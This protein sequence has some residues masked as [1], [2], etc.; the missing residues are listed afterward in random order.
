MFCGQCGKNLPDDVRFCQSCGRPTA[1]APIPTSFANATAAAAAPAPALSS[2]PAPGTTSDQQLVKHYAEMSDQELMNVA[3]DVASLEDDARMVIASELSRRKLSE[4]DI[5][6]YQQD[7]AAFKP[8]DFWRELRGVRGWLFLFCASTTIV[9]PIFFLRDALSSSGQPITFCVNLPMAVFAFYT[10][11]SLWR[12]R[13]NALKLV[14]VY[15]LVQL[16]LAA[17]SFLAVVVGARM[18]AYQGGTEYQTAEMVTTDALNSLRT[19]LFVWIWWSYFKRSKRVQA[20]Y[21][22]NL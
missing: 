6:Q 5:I 14:K 1:P 2:S 15:F 13:L 22:L 10:G 21:G 3:G 16:A 20:T 9:Q 8:K 7:V 17:L 4:S 19:A 18:G 11:I 12:V